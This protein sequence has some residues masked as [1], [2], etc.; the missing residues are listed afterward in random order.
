MRAR[1]AYINY[2]KNLRI[3]NIL[4]YFCVVYVNDL[5]QCVEAAAKLFADDTKLY[6]NILSKEDCDQLQQDLNSL[7][8]WSRSW[9]LRFNEAKCVVVKIRA[10][11][12]YSYTLNGSCLECVHHQKYLG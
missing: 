4:K 9:L 6:N 12:D 5:P 7:A 10:A 2:T 3:F 8:A 1:I 11:I